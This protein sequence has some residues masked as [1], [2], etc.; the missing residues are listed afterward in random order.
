[1]RFLFFLFF[2]LLS[3][4]INISE[5]KKLIL[6][7]LGDPGKTIQGERWSFF[8]DGVMGGLSEGKAII[9]S[10][11]NIPCYKMTGNVT[12]ENNGG[13]IQIRTPINPLINA[14]EFKGIYL[15]IFG[16]NNKYSIHIRTPL[17]SAPWQYYSY[18]F[19][20]QNQW[21]EIK[22]PFKDFK[23]SNFY[24]LKKLS[25]QQI[26]S[27]GLVAGFSNFIADICLSEIG[28]Y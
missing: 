13:F 20:A 2:L 26:K 11:E 3:V 1:M 14:D 27:I 16:N 10:I 25:N 17:T 7:E 4:K 22:A 6:D 28:F 21:I 5:A 9:S 12:T 15:K 8:T 24:K 19:N 23:R 18:S